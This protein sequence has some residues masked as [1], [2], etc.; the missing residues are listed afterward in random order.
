MATCVGSNPLAPPITT[1][2]ARLRR[3][4]SPD[5][6]VQSLDTEVWWSVWFTHGALPRSGRVRPLGSWVAGPVL[7]PSVTFRHRYWPPR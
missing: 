1:S 3:D 6:L 5:H 4:E 2:D 7:V